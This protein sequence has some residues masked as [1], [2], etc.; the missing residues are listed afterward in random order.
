MAVLTV[1]RHHAYDIVIGSVKTHASHTGGNSSH[2]AHGAFRE[3][4]CTAAAIGKQNVGRAV[5]EFYANDLVALQYFNG[6]LPL[7]VHSGI[8]GE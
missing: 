7:N 4:D 2:L 1:H 8:F 6:F 5:G 3:V